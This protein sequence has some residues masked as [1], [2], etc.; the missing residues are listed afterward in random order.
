MPCNALSS[1]TALVVNRLQV[2]DLRHNLK[3]AYGPFLDDIP[4]RLGRN[5][6]LDTA[7][8]ALFMAASGELS[9][10]S[11]LNYTRALQA[12]RMAI[13]ESKE[14]LTADTMCAIYFLW[15]LQV[16]RR[17]WI[18]PHLVRMSNYAPA[19]IRRVKQ[20]FIACRR[21]RTDLEPR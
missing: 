9:N 6:A 8:R 3:W 7:T 18:H 4:V 11:L 13:L 15:L 19:P 20:K 10:E 5:N 17:T 1:L 16:C 21:Y 2:K 12:T 14:A